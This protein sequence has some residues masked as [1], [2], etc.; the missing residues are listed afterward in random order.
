[1]EECALRFTFD[2]IE[3]WAFA[4]DYFGERVVDWDAV[5]RW[6]EVSGFEIDDEGNETEEDHNEC[7]DFYDAMAEHFEALE[8]GGILTIRVTETVDI[9]ELLGAYDTGKVDGKESARKYAALYEQAV[10]ES[11]TN[12]YP[13][14]EIEVSISAP[15]EGESYLN[16]SID[17]SG[18]NR[19]E[20]A[21]ELEREIRIACREIRQSVSEYQDNSWIVFVGDEE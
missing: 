3:A 17:V 7:L 11:L 9:D 10:I 6:V 12:S 18:G 21:Y 13:E 2:D 14:A 20:L 5:R 15:D 19:H 4:K 16:L 1:M 8:G